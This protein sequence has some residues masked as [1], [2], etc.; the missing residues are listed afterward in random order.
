MKEGIQSSLQEI[1]R[2]YTTTKRLVLRAEE[3]D[4]ENRSNISVFKEQRDALDH[5]MRALAK[6][7]EGS[8]Q[9]DYIPLQIDKAKGHLYRASYDSVDGIVVSTKIRIEEMLK[10]V[11]NESISAVLPSYWSE[12]LPRIDSISEKIA[13]HRELKDV[14]DLTGDHLDEYLRDAEDL[15]DIGHRIASCIHA[16]QE[17]GKRTRWKK[18]QDKLFWPLAVGVILLLIRLILMS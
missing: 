6:H 10:G 3:L 11:S 7:L 2:V 17:H 18:I 13:Q 9:D 5:L 8:E 14:G 1:L 15:S 4:A 12:I 16:M